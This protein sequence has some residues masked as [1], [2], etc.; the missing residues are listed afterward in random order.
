M[1]SE[2]AGPTGG[3]GRAGAAVRSRQDAGGKPVLGRTSRGMV[4]TWGTIMT[5]FFL[6]PYL[7][8]WSVKA[9]FAPN[10][11]VSVS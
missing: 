8:Q 10:V 1:S 7:T 6:F 5:L 9:F 3:N 11:S 2:G 4:R